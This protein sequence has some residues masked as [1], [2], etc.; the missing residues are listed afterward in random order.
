MPETN[1]SFDG[2]II[3][4]CN[5]DVI[6][7]C[8]VGAPASFGSCLGNI[9]WCI[10]SGRYGDVDLAGCIAQIAVNAPGPYFDDGNWRI[11]L[12]G[13][14]SATPAQRNAVE[15]IFLGRAGGFFD[16]WREL[17]NEVVG[18]RWLP[19]D[20][21]RVGW[22]RIVRIEGVLE[23]DAE[24]IAGADGEGVA[25]LVNPP[26]WK[27]APFDAILGRSK[28][29]VYKDFDLGWDGDGKACSFSKCHYEGP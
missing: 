27:G 23:I 19:I 22:K 5:C 12:Y 4:T 16:H 10:D 1:W 2:E 20:V 7:P 18:V 11:V 21:Q 8:T 28:R 9:T 6:C 17:T 13:D 15:T 24:A 3:D 25:Q 26:F 29:Y 14:D